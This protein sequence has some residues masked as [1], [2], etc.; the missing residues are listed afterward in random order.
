M[1]AVETPNLADR[2]SERMSVNLKTF[3]K[4]LLRIYERVVVNLAGR[5][6]PNSRERVRENIVVVKRRG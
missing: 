2:G 6:G 5:K 3:R 4:A 1:S